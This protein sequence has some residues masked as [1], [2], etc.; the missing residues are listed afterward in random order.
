MSLPCHLAPAPPALA[1]HPLQDKY[2]A[3]GSWLAV[4]VGPE[5]CAR[6]KARE[7]QPVDMAAGNNKCCWCDCCYACCS[8]IA[9]GGV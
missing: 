8:G 7:A 5:A 2:T 9:L 4:A 3:Q 6:L 1:L